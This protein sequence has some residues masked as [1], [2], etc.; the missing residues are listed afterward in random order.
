MPNSVI[1]TPLNRHPEAVD[2]V[3]V[4]QDERGNYNTALPVGEGGPNLPVPDHAYATS[5]EVQDRIAN[6][7]GKQTDPS[8]NP[9]DSRA[10]YSKDKQVRIIQSPVEEV[11]VAGHQELAINERQ[12]YEQQIAHLIDQINTLNTHV[13][14]FQ[15]QKRV[16]HYRAQSP[17]EHN[18]FRMNSSIGS[19]PERSQLRS[20]LPLQQA[21]D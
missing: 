8:R 14:E 17:S 7:L 18:L 1:V 6:D 21:R 9:D 15:Q 10:N 3:L 13:K 20:D 16:T 4:I 12:Q 19:S 11:M 5:Y 2:G